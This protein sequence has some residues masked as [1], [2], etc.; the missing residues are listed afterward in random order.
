MSLP[1]Q[2]RSYRLQLTRL[3]ASLPPTNTRRDYPKSCSEFARYWTRQQLLSMPTSTEHLLYPSTGIKL[4]H[5]KQSRLHGKRLENDRHHHRIRIQGRMG[6]RRD[7]GNQRKLTMI[8]SRDMQCSAWS[9]RLSLHRRAGLE[10]GAG[11]PGRRLQEG[12]WNIKDI[13]RRSAVLFVKL[14]SSKCWR[15]VDESKGNTRQRK[16]P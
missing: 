10:D 9:A 1:L 2:F 15:N 6:V 3:S 13:S 11:R 14:E 7:A 16:R 12:V 8:F 5:I 4:G